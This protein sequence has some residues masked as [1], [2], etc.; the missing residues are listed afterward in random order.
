M[1]GQ[2][3]LGAEHTF[4]N[5]HDVLCLVIHGHG[6]HHVFGRCLLCFRDDFV[7]GLGLGGLAFSGESHATR[8]VPEDGGDL[9]RRIGLL[10]GKDCVPLVKAHIDRHWNGHEALQ[11]RHVLHTGRDMR[12]EHVSIL[13]RLGVVAIHGSAH[14]DEVQVVAV[15]HHRVDAL[16]AARLDVSAVSRCREFIRLHGSFVVAGPNVDVG[17]HVHEV[18]CGRRHGGELVRSGECALWT[19]RCLHCVDVVVD[20][21]HVVGIAFQNRL[22]RR[23][24]FFG[25]VLGGSVDVPQAPGMQVHSRFREERRGI[26]IV[27]KILHYFAHGIAIIFGGFAT[28]GFW[29]GREALRHRLDVGLLVGR[30]AGREIHRFLDGIV[31]RLEAFVTGGIVVVGANGFGNAPVRD[32]QFLIKI[33]SALEGT[34]RLIMIEGINEP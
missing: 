34:G 25:A 2:G 27:R 14:R 19:A 11:R 15:V 28:V 1:F 29:I 7:L 4:G 26:E 24:D 3:D 10:H 21:S 8:K 32:G 6:E 31:G 17:G 13:L 18:S 20:R 12:G 22:Q 16:H 9:H 5:L 23:D 33:G 30:R